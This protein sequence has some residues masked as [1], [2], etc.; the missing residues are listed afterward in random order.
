MKRRAMLVLAMAGCT[1]SRVDAAP[2]ELHP[3]AHDRLCVTKGAITDAAIG[4]PTVRAFALG[5]HGDAAQLTFTFAGDSDRAR[6]LA[7]GQQR[8]QLGLKLR[9]ADSCNVVY[10]MWR[11]DPHPKLEVSVKYNPG[12]RTHEECG[13]SGYTKVH[14]EHATAVP[15]LEVGAS[16]T[17]RAEIRGDQLVAWI[18]GAVA[19]RGE[20]PDE[21]RHIAGPAGL[22]SDNVRLEAIQLAGL[23][24]DA[25]PECKRHEEDD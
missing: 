22:R 17:L 18:D 25:G 6:A 5:S 16:H 2:I 10:V 3:I 13:A 12:K 4:E 20:L 15:A 8:R 9:A 24:G 21:A 23:P 7:S 1:S 14:P 11:L 19:W